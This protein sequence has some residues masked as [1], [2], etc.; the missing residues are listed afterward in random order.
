[1]PLPAGFKVNG[2]KIA[3]H[4]RLPLPPR[5]RKLISLLDKLPMGDVLTSIE[6][7][8]RA[9]VSLTGEVLQVLE[10]TE[11]REK[12]DNKLFWGSRKS[13][14]QLRKKLAEPEDT[15]DHN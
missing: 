5:A 3:T 13:I 6:L 12:V 15:S 2:S 4:N 14:A 1:M 11:Y 10:L 9:G 8:A 7:R